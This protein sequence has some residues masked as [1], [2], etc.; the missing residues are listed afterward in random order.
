MKPAA[1]VPL[2]A[3]ALLLGVPAA[4]AACTISTTSVA[5]GAY[6]PFNPV[7][8]DGTGILTVGCTPPTSTTASLS[9][10]FGTYAARLLSSG[11]SQITYNLYTTAAR[12][13]VWGDGTA[14]T[15]T[16]S[17]SGRNQTYTVFGRIPA[18]QNV[19]AGTY[20]DTL[21]ATITF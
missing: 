6:S 4:Q 7:N 14:G 3:A 12:T 5:F 1:R 21:V 15:G 8:L 19:S 20:A 2:L 16:V 9:T 11:A 17:L 10:G 13:T 18:Q